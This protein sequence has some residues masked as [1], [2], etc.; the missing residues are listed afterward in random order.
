MKVILLAVL[1]LFNQLELV[2]SS[3]TNKNL[4]Q[5]D[6]TL[7]RKVVIETVF[8]NQK[9]QTTPKMNNDEF[10]IIQSIKDT[11]KIPFSRVFLGI[12]LILFVGWLNHRINEVYNKYNLAS[13][14][15][16]AEKIKVF[17]H[18]FIWLITVIIII[19]FIF[20]RSNL[21]M[22]SLFVF[23]VV[24]S[25][26]SLQD[27]GKSV[28][29]GIY[30]LLDKPFDN[31]DWIKVRNY[32]GKVHSKNLRYTEIITEED[33][34]IRIPNSIFL[35]SPVENLNVISKNKQVN[36][37]VEIPRKVDITLAKKILEEV[38]SLSVYHSINKPVN[39]IY[40]GISKNGNYSF[41]VKAFV[42]DARFESDFNSD[43]QESIAKIFHNE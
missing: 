36:F 16:H 3:K 1:L 41:Q 5:Q 17:L 20:Y 23:I 7:N 9:V 15:K 29:G 31:G 32:Y 10:L 43:V 11:L 25:I 30:I 2:D 35:F 27:I 18:I 26:I 8:V 19:Q 21:L 39:I 6:S 40:Q 28:V 37:K 12:I 22:I 38:V 14:F 34:L 24:L 33:S 42:F 4:Y 13:K